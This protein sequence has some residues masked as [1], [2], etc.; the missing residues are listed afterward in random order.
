MGSWTHCPRAAAAALLA[1]ILSGAG[2]CRESVGSAGGRDQ[3]L[4]RAPLEARDQGS[5]SV[6]V[7]DGARV[8]AIGGGLVALDAQNG[9]VAWRAPLTKYAPINV[10]LGGGRV[11]AVEELAYAF[12]AATGRELW[13]F[14][15][16]SDGALGESTADDRALYFGT[17]SHRVY[18]LDAATG[19]PLWT[20][21]VG[22]DWEHTGIVL[23][24]T[25]SGDT[26]YAAVRQYNAANGYIST[27]WIFALDR[28]TGRVLWSYRNGEGK[29][30]R[31]VSSAPTVAGRLLLASDLH[32]NSFFA[33][34]RLTGK[35]V[36]RV[37]GARG[38]VG[39]RQAPSAVGEMAYIT[40]SDT[41]AYAVELQTGRIVWKKKLPASSNSFAVCGD[42]IFA[43]W[44]GL[45][46]LDRNTGRVLYQSDDESSDY[47]TSGF[48]VHDDRVFVLGN[49]AAYAYR[50]R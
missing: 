44:L 18:A 29:D 42:R 2:A 1:C 15:P 46:I 37:N 7:T 10:A 17:G 26:L 6:P 33:V 30:I 11:F 22:P 49:R 43:A 34:D 32:G 35:E 13:R 31:S 9:S 5:I 8:Y 48:A 27:G 25:V 28:G 21:D 38:Y 36:W 41:H 23:G 47:P 24:V 40:S 12:D 4:W 16:D 20:T 19:Q 3:L 45:S 39:P 14:T 50:C